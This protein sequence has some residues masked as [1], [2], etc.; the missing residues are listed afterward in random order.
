MKKSITLFFLVAIISIVSSQS[1]LDRQKAT[2]QKD[3]LKKSKI[4]V[5]QQENKLDS[6][7]IS[8]GKFKIYKKEA[9]ASYYADKFNGRRTTSGRKFDN[10][11][12]TAAHKK[13][14][15]GTKVKVT[16]EKNGKSVIVE[17]TDRGPFVKS[18]EIDLSKRAFMDIASNK[19]SGGILVTIAV[20]SN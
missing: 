15:F 14:P 8:L 18:R 2:V 20:L 1:S 19:S 3:T 11:K 16:N 5:E 13:L 6:L 10:N 17:I 4:A 9:H 7:V 12:Y